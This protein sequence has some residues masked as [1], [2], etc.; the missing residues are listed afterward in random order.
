MNFM[1]F[2]DDF[3]G[4]SLQVKIQHFKLKISWFQHRVHIIM[5]L[6]WSC[7]LVKI[8]EIPPEKVRH[9]ETPL[10]GFPG[11]LLHLDYKYTQRPVRTVGRTC[12]LKWTSVWKLF[13]KKRQLVEQQSGQDEDEDRRAGHAGDDERRQRRRWRG[14]GASGGE[15]NCYTVLQNLKTMSWIVW[16]STK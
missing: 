8:R 3:L 7:M 10:L 13:Y 1:Q 15:T 4:N 11:R 2:K 16:I 14:G 12:R 9:L 6:V 5:W